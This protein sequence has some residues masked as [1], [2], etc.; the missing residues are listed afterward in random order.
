MLE[1]FQLAG[2]NTKLIAT[3]AYQSSDLRLKPAQRPRK[4][5]TTPTLFTPKP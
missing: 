2:L 4:A 3:R 5:R 1:A